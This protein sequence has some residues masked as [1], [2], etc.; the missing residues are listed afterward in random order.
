MCVHQIMAQQM[1]YRLQVA[2]AGSRTMNVGVWLLP[3]DEDVFDLALRTVFPGIA[4]RCSQP[5]PWGLHPVHLHDSLAN[6]MGCGGR[7][8]Q[9]FLHL[10]IGAGLP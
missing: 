6:A 10:P 2:Y 8:V 4:W 1:S 3:E 7:G 5:G 9:S